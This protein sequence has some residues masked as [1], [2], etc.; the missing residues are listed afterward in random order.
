MEDEL[1]G[2]V[3]VTPKNI[4]PAALTL[5]K[6]F[7]NYPIS[8][9]FEPND[10]KRKK[11]QPKIFR[12]VLQDNI[13]NGIVYSTSSEMKGVAVWALIDNKK[14]LSKPRRTIGKWFRSLFEDKEHRRRQQAF[15]DYS[16]AVRS[17]VVPDKYWYLQILAV[18]PAYQGRGLA[19][20]LLRPMLARADREG[21]PVYL[22]TQLQ[23]NVTLYEH[24]GFKVAEEGDI[25]GSNV[26]SWAMVREPGKGENH[27]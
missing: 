17:R 23:K 4:K 1:N 7:E 8:V 19:G 2:I 21:L 11:Q 24:F 13:A 22:E 5:A 25:P 15:F 9:F 26:H 27:G 6:A 14:P 20:R 3:R 12:M 18:A 16:S 10:A